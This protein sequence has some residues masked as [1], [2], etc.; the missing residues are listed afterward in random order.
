LVAG[1]RENIIA[2]IEVF[3]VGGPSK[4]V[5]IWASF[6]CVNWYEP[7]E[8]ILSKNLFPVCF[9]V[10]VEFR[11]FLFVFFV[12]TFDRR[13]VFQHQ[14]NMKFQEHR[15][16]ERKNKDETIANQ[17]DSDV[18]DVF[19]KNLHI[20]QVQDDQIDPIKFREVHVNGQ[21]GSVD[22]KLHE[23]LSVVKADAVVNPRTMMVHVQHARVAHRAMVRALGLEGVANQAVSLSLVVVVP[24]VKSPVQ[25]NVAWLRVH[26]PKKRPHQHEQKHVKHDQ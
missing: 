14:L 11:V 3:F 16:N 6:F 19:I 13:A 15:N 20:N 22:Q 25:R 4:S 5:A 17:N 1:V 24:D 26:R 23:K 18:N 12:Q 8:F 21:N 2:F 7:K 10:D 9:C